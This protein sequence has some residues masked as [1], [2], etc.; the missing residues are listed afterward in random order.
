MVCFLGFMLSCCVFLREGLVR[1]A[2]N[3]IGVLPAGEEERMEEEED[4]GDEEENSL[5]V[6]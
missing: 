4:G 2:H 1:R 6:F 5:R 3:T